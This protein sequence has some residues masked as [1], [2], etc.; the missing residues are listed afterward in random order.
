[1]RSDKL[2]CLSKSNVHQCSW[3]FVMR[4][5]ISLKS[6]FC[7]CAIL[8]VVQLVWFAQC[9]FVVQD[10]VSIAHILPSISCT[11]LWLP[12]Q[13]HNKMQDIVPAFG[14]HHS[15]LSSSLVSVALFFLL[16]LGSQFHFH[17]HS[18]HLPVHLAMSLLWSTLLSTLFVRLL[19]SRPSVALWYAL[20]DL[21]LLGTHPTLNGGVFDVNGNFDV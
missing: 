7:T 6:S 10:K 18:W 11:I 21:K 13:E 4:L 20:L 8:C 1:M 17:C 2:K 14:M 12:P 19:L 15:V 9:N 16:A 5:S 3:V